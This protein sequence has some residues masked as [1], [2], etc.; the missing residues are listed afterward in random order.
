MLFL[1]TSLRQDGLELPIFTSEGVP[2]NSF[3]GYHGGADRA[4]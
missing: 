2:L 1:G 3:D 4:C